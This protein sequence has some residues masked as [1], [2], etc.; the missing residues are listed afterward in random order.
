VKE[1]VTT[2]RPDLLQLHGSETPTRVA[3]IVRTGGVPAMKAIKVATR[4]DARLADAYREVGCLVLFDAKPADEAS[5]SLPG[6]NGI[7]FDWRAIAGEDARGPFMLSGGLTPENIGEAM[8]LTRASMVDVSS[9]VERSPG[10]K[11][12]VLIHAFIT[13]ARSAASA[14]DNGTPEP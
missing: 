10:I 3:E 9:G 4:E 11:D 7:P 2:V 6:G 8:R 12:P 13:A 1:A 14:I 5:K